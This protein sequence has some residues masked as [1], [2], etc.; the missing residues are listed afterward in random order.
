MSRTSIKKNIEKLNKEDTYALMMVLLYASKN[1]PR[2]SALNELAYL[3]DEKSFKNFI[4]YYGGQIIR[5][6]TYEEMQNSLK[7]LLL[8]QF[9]KVENQ[10]WQTAL[11][12][13]GFEPAETFSAK[14]RLIKF[15]EHIDEYEYEKGGVIGN[16]NK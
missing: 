15:I 1:N 16:A 7:T 3:L 9:Y 5:V 8:Y 2:Y 4:K 6:P 12:L 10:D 11:K 13:A 14:R